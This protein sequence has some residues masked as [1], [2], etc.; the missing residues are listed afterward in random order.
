MAIEVASISELDDADV[1]QAYEYAT[2][3]VQEQHSDIDAKRG[4]IGDLL[5]GLDAILSAAH[6]TNTD[7]VRESQSVALIESDPNLADETL[8]DNAV[9]NYRIT[10][11]V[12]TEAAGEVVIVLDAQAVTSIAAG[13]V[14]TSGSQTYLSDATYTARLTAGEVIEA[15]DRLLTALASGNYAFSINVTATEA[16]SAGLLSIDD[17]LTPAIEPPNFVRAYA[18]SDF[19]GGLDAQTN[20]EL[21]ALMQSGMAVRAYSN[22]PAIESM[23]RNASPD[24]YDVVTDEFANILDMS[25]IGFGD[26]EMT[27]D[28]HWIFPISGGGKTDIYVR[29]QRL[30]AHVSVTKTALLIQKVGNDGIWQTT[31][32]RTDAPGF[33]E[34][35]NVRLAGTEADGT[36]YVLQTDVRGTDLTGTDYIPD[37]ETDAE[38][39]FSRFQTGAIT[40]L[41]TDTDTAALTEGV[42]TQEYDVT[43]SYMPLISEI[44][45]FLGDRD[46][47]NPSGDHLVKAAVPAFIE[48]TVAVAR[49][50]PDVTV[51]EDELADALADYVN[52]RGFAGYL[53]AAPLATAGIATLSAGTTI[54]SITMDMRILGPDGTTVTNSSTEVLA[55]SD[56]PQYYITPNT[57]VFILDPDDVTVVVTDV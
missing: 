40:F 25:I 2:S 41:D 15:T 10:R 38:G 1:S 57:V 43:L 8:V 53:Y 55:V 56:L 9:S 50:D 6:K 16:G 23:I 22:R 3:L 19:S 54:S 35:T 32:S 17:E 39:G 21:L 44:Q 45:Q 49:T 33:Y 7:R 11:Q 18:A 29:S 26:D 20:E 42:D 36:N 34:I 31:I 30:P 24:E 5:L 46:V 4:V 51:D 47:V 28:Q 52:T 14:F 48:L 12:A 13:S 37:I 27:R